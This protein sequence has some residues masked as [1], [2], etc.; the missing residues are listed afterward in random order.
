M[1]IHTEGQPCSDV[2]GVPVLND[3][4]ARRSPP[5]PSRSVGHL[6]LPPTGIS[7]RRSCGRAIHDFLL[8][9]SADTFKLFVPE[10]A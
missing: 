5:P 1:S 3:P 6:R 2:S 7:C 9:D 8:F 4:H 10:T